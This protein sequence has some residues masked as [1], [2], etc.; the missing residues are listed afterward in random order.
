MAASPDGPTTLVSR[1]AVHAATTL[2][3]ALCLLAVAAVGA[4]L[5]LGTEST[6]WIELG[7]YLPFPVYLAPAVL[8]LLLSLRQSW[9]WRAAALAALAV[10]L[11]PIMGLQLNRG[12][13][14]LAPLRVMSFNIKAYL[15][16]DKPG[17]Y[18]RIAWEIALHDADL[19]ALQDAGLASN[20]ESLPEP[21]KTA[22]GSRQ[23][24]ISGQYLVAS[25][26]PMRDCRSGDISFPGE[27]HHYVVCTIT[28]HGVEFDFATAHLLSP[29]EGLNATRHERLGGLD[30][31]RENFAMRMIQAHRLAQDVAAHPRPLVLAGDLNA[32]DSSPVIERLRDA[33]LRD[34]FAAAGLGYGYTYGHSLRPRFSF[35]RID[36]V[37]VSAGI[38]VKESAVG[39]S[40]ASAHRPVIADLW[41]KRE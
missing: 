18:G 30:D 31:W 28:A 15:A 14:G 27:G 26:F 1:P 22:L 41:L 2:I 16:D 23:I 24:H 17:G 10:V 21:F 8:A 4:A 13:E 36:H 11:V 32:P 20:V 39:G 25:R 35:L 12:E 34:S 6:W 33:G 38:G 9:R 29:R 3:G 5:A 40:Q 7:R 37:M 19:V